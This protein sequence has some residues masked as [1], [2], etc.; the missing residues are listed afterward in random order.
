MTENRSATP[1]RS[2]LGKWIAENPLPAVSIAGAL[3]Y[4]AMRISYVGFYG[5][6]GLD[7]EDVGIGY[8]ATLSRAL[9][10]V[11]FWAAVL[12]LIPGVVLVAIAWYVDRS[13]WRHTIR[14]LAPRLA[15]GAI[16]LLLLLT[17]FDAQRA[18]LAVKRG[19]ELR[20]PSGLVSRGTFRDPLGFTV[21]E[22][23]VEWVGGEASSRT[24]LGRPLMLLG[25]DSDVYYVYDVQFERTLRLPRS[26]VVVREDIG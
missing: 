1:E 22:V 25:S 11:L 9:P 16:V 26:L 23:E 17:P 15:V 20:A 24:E 5:E 14:R 3:V 6:F 18:A 12:V 10:G 19:E 4:G 21:R 8:A 7:P 2:G 13:G